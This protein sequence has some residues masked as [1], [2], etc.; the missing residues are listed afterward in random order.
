MIWANAVAIIKNDLIDLTLQTSLHWAQDRVK[1]R[2]IKKPAKVTSLSHER[3][4]R[5]RSAVLP[6]LVLNYSDY[7]S[8]DYG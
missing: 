8:L 5:K 4:K 6:R 1:W 2:A 7:T 3:G